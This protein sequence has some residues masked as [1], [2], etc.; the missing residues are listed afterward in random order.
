MVSA[1]TRFKS[2]PI[3]EVKRELLGRAKENRNPFLYTIFS[4]IAPVIEGLRSVERE[5]WARAFGAL[6]VPHEERAAGAAARGDAATARKHYLIAY[7]YYHVA[8]YPAPN[9]PGK[10]AA[11]RKS[12]ENYW[13]AARYFDRRPG[14]R[15]VAR[16]SRLELLL[17]SQ[18]QAL[19]PARCLRIVA[20][21]TITKEEIGA[22]VAVEVCDF[23]IETVA[24]RRRR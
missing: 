23:D 10:L 11:Y 12:Q 5:E 24:G 18:E 20:R 22:A 8:R 15:V 4:E 19:H 21:R 16:R 2:R 17:A 14:L 1:A 9:S 3:E 6:A 13:K 7:D